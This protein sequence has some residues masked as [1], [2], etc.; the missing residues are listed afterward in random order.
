MFM[1]A[2]SPLSEAKLRVEH[3]RRDTGELQRQLLTLL[4]LSW[5]T[6]DDRVSG[7]RFCPVH[8]EQSQS[9]VPSNEASPPQYG[10]A[11]A[12]A[13]FTLAQYCEFDLCQ[14]LRTENRAFPII[15]WLKGLPM[16]LVLLE[17]AT[18][19]DEANHVFVVC[20]LFNQAP[21]R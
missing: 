20:N 21:I 19:V 15:T 4:G 5:P 13:N 17:L 14:T 9:D 7:R 6:M 1:A 12:I 2:F 18:F 16:N 11:L 3:R 10:L 8:Q